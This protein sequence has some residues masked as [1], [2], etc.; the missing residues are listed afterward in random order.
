MCVRV[1]SPCFQCSYFRVLILAED[2]LDELFVDVVVLFD[3]FGDGEHVRVGDGCEVHDD[4]VLVVW[5]EVFSCGVW[6]GVCVFVRVLGS[7]GGL[8]LGRDLV[9]V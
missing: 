5:K 9:S 2:R 8:V 4:R 3:E 1:L 6:D 7:V